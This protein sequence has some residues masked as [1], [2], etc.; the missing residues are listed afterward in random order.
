MESVF[1]ESVKHLSC[2]GSLVIY[3][4]FIDATVPT[5]QSNLSFDFSLR[6]RDEQWGL[7]DLEDVIKLAEKSGFKLEQRLA[8]PSNNLIIHFKL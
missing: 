7:R 6:Q 3:G 8:V 4:P 2:G 5:S 1:N